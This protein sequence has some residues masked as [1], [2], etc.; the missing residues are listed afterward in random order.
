MSGWEQTLHRRLLGRVDE[1]DDLVQGARGLEAVAE[2]EVVVVAQTHAAEDDLVHVG[3]QGH[4]GHDLVVRLVRVGEERDLLAGDQG[5]VEVDAGDAGRDQLGR[6]AALVGVDGRTADL[7]LLAFDLGTAVDRL[8]VGVEEASGE[9]VAHAEGR[10]CALEGDLG[11]GR[12]AFRAGEYLEGDAVALGLDD[13]GQLAADRGQLVVRYALR[14]EG[15]RGL[16]DGLE[17]RVCALEC[18]RCH[19]SG[20]L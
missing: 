18:F 6:L 17:L 20:E 5:V 2:E 13:L 19:R 9:L 10:R 8:A 11:V 1:G 16:G 7:A 4:V 15:Y 3:A 12:N 14:V